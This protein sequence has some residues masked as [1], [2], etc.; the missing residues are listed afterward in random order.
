[1]ML[2]NGMQLTQPSIT[3]YSFLPLLNFVV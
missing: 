2:S 1:M 3:S